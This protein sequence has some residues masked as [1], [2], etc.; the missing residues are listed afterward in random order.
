MDANTKTRTPAIRALLTPNFPE[1][2]PAGSVNTATTSRAI[3]IIQ[4]WTM[5]FIANSPAMDGTPMTMPAD[6][7]TAKKDVRNDTITTEVSMSNF[8]MSSPNNLH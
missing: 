6:K 5:L 8:I 2:W 7:K 1:I 3:V 4:F